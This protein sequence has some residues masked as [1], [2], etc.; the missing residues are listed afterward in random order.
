VDLNSGRASGTNDIADERPSSLALKVWPR[1]RDSSIQPES[2]FYS[3]PYGEL[4][5][6]TPPVMVGSSRQVSSGTD[7]ETNQYSSVYGRRNVSGKA[8]EEGLVGTKGGY[9]RY[10]VM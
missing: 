4:K 5:P 1:N 10:S 7:L 3:K 9:S 2:D 6:A 8:A